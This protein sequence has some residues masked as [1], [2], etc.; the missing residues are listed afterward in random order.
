MYWVPYGIARWACGAGEYAQL[1]DQDDDS[2]Q[3]S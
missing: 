3:V 2:P 1:E